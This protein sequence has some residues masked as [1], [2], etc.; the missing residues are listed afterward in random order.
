M[1]S[2][3][4]VLQRQSWASNAPR[5][6]ALRRFCGL[7]IVC[8]FLAGCATPRRAAMPIMPPPLDTPQL[9]TSWAEPF[10][11]LDAARWRHEEVK[12]RHT[13]YD[14][15][16]LEGRRC[17]RAKSDNGAS[18]LLTPL[19]IDPERDEWLSWQWRV[20]QLVDGEAL[21]RKQGSDAAARM[22]V[23]FDRPGL[24]WQNRSIDYVWSG[25]LPL[26]TVLDSAFSSESKIIVAESGRAGLG[27]WR[28]VKRNVKED[29]RRLF[30]GRAP[31]IIAIG[32]MSDTDNTGGHALAY[33]DELQFGQ[34]VTAA[35]GQPQMSN[36]AK[37]EA[38]STDAQSA[39]PP[40][41]RL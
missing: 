34:L 33:F 21:K 25:S 9:L 11:A 22:Y 2:L 40:H 8:G 41:D 10:D 38:H 23:Y 14:V 6:G 24:P 5:T 35:E 4:H 28:T 31:P 36:A 13:N 17:L 19:H 18:I 3:Q 20:D 15:V 27:Q 7:G 29:Y 32:I 26:G 16:E 1:N 30:G 39:A 12:R 37:R